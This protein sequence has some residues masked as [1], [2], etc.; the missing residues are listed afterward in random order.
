MLIHVAVFIFTVFHWKSILQVVYL[1]LLVGI[2]FVS[3]FELLQTLLLWTFL[4]MFLGCIYATVSEGDVLG[5][6]LLGQ[7]I[8]TQSPLLNNAKMV[9]SCHQCRRITVA[10]SPCQHLILLYLNFFASLCFA[11][12]WWG[13]G[14]FYRFPYWSSYSSLLPIFLFDCMIIVLFLF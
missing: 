8:G 9:S 14:S 6:E 2:W 7:D 1:L 13:W 4:S 5:V 10:P 12:Y 11:C 3:S